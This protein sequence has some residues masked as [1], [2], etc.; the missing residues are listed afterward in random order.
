MRTTTFRS[1]AMKASEIEF[2]ISR[3][4]S[5]LSA[6]TGNCR[7]IT[8]TQGTVVKTSTAGKEV[9]VAD[10]DSGKW[11][12]GARGVNRATYAK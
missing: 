12:V 2:D 3:D 5:Q 6:A 10:Q 9:C 4:G 11:V 1:P 8:V 7:I